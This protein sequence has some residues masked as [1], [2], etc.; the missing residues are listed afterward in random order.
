[1]YVLVENTGNDGI[2]LSQA[3]KAMTQKQGF[4]QALDSQRMTFK[5]FVQLW[6]EFELTGRGSATRV[7]IVAPNRQR[8]GPLDMFAQ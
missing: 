4:K 5:Q 7:V 2:S 3:A 8:R 6:P 1:M